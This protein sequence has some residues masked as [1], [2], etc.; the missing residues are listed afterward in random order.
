MSD[1]EDREWNDRFGES[2]L[3]AGGVK[4]LN[5]GRLDQLEEEFLQEAEVPDRRGTGCIKWDLA[6]P[7]E[8]PLWVADMDFPV[9]PVITEALQKRLEHPVFGYSFEP[10]GYFEAV[11][12]W[13]AGRNGW[14]V[15]ADHL[16][17]VPSVMQGLAVAAEEFTRP[18]DR[19]GLF[20]PV[21][22]PFFDVI[23]EMGRQVV[24][25]PMRIEDGGEG[26]VGPARRARPRYAL[27][28]DAL[29]REASSLSLLILCSPH[30]PGGRV[31]G[32]DE[33]AR[34]RSIT[35]AAGLRVIS[36]E[37]HGDLT[38]PGGRFVPW[39][40]V[41][42]K[43]AGDGRE[44]GTGDIAL[45]A[46]SKT[47]NIP[48]LPTAIAAVPD[49][50]TRERLKAALHAHM[51]KM[52]NLLTM[53]AALAAYSGAA[54][55]LDELRPVLQDH[56]RLV[57]DRC[58]T[59]PGVRVF[60][61]EGTYVAWLDLRERWGLPLTPELPVAVGRTGPASSTGDGA[62]G[63]AGDGGPGNPGISTRFT[64]H[65]RRNGVWLSDGSGYGPE[66]DGFMRL[67]FATSR[68]LLTEGLNRLVQSIE[69]FEP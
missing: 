34:L 38:F 36:D 22:T 60:A 57:V 29:E 42:G 13:Q 67:N 31:W 50:P 7:D 10:E 35:G 64:A 12:A 62:G 30:N 46:P 6:G 44:G 56:Y 8:I 66:G 54:G 3:G 23:E 69:T 21:Y 27:N 51:Q 33:L 40:R 58:D 43:A 25:I 24:R 14:V 55:W 53:E 2:Y 26:G 47:F 65:C 37:I 45:F 52:S 20:T 28:F 61:M 17:V 32:E 59:L 48:G 4:E 5:E 63:A 16:V 1:A 11:R 15:E 41:V 68:E 49:G 19:I 9:A 39:L 18:G